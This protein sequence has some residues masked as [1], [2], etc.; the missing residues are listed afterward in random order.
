M[1]IKDEFARLDYM[2]RYNVT[3]DMG[4]KWKYA[5]GPNN[6]GGTMGFFN[7]KNDVLLFLD[8]IKFIRGI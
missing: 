7:Y 2:V 4:R 5:I 6:S 3:D 8:R 1:N